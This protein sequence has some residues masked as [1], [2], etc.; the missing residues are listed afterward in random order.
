MPLSILPI[1]VPVNY[2]SY[3][4]ALDISGLRGEKTI[5]LNGSFDGLILVYG[6]HNGVNFA[7][8]FSFMGARPQSIKQIFNSS[9]QFIVLRCLARDMVAVNASISGEY[10]AVANSFASLPVVPAGAY[11]PQAIVDLFTLAP[12]DGL[13]EGTNLI[14][15]G[16]FVG[17]I[18]IEGSLDGLRFSPVASFK[19]LSRP[20]LGSG[21]QTTI[22]EHSPF[23]YTQQVR[24]LRVNVL[25]GTFVNGPLTITIGGENE[26]VADSATFLAEPVTNAAGSALLA[27]EVVRITGNEAVGRAQS[28]LV[29]NVNGLVGAMLHDTPLG[30]IDEVVNAGKGFVLL[31]AG[32]TP[33]PGDPLWVSE[34]TA[35]RATNVTPVIKAYMGVVK[36][37]SIYAATGGVIADINPGFTIAANVPATLAQ[38][39][40]VGVAP[41]DQTLILTDL[42]GGALVINATTPPPLF[43]GVTTFE[44]NVIGGSTNFYRIGGFDVSSAFTRAAALGMAWDEVAFLSST[45]TISG[46]T[47]PAITSLSMVTFEAG[48]ITAANPQTIGT[49]ATVTIEG[50]PTASNA[51]GASPTL[52]MPLALDVQTGDAHVSSG[53]LWTVKGITGTGVF[54]STYP[55]ALTTVLHQYDTQTTL[56]PVFLG[57]GNGVGGTNLS[58]SKSRSATGNAQAAVLNND[59]LATLSF[60]GDDGVDI[61]SGLAAQ[62]AV[63]VNGAPGIASVP[64]M[65]TFATNPVG[66]FAPV[67]RMRITSAGEVMVATTAATALANSKLVVKADATVA[68]PIAGTLWHGFELQPATM[69]LAAGGTVPDA[70]SLAYLAPPTITSPVAYVLPMGATLTIAGPPA[71]GGAL[72][73][74]NPLSLAVLDGTVATYFGIGGGDLIAS[75]FGGGAISLINQVDS[76]TY[77]NTVLAGFGNNDSGAELY[78]IKSRS[79]D[80]NASAIAQ[81]NDEVGSLYFEMDD[82]AGTASD[83]AIIEVR[84]DG[85][86][87]VGDTPGRIVFKTTPQGTFTP[88]ERMRIT[89][90]GN[91]LLGLTTDV[92]SSRLRVQADKTITAAGGALWNGIEFVA[93]T[94]TIGG[95]T[96]PITTMC[97]FSVAG[98]TITAA[99]AVVTTDF[100]TSRF[101]AA[102]FIGAG[103]ASATRSYSLFSEGNS[104]FGGGLTFKATDINAAGPYNVLETDFY[105]EVRYTATGAISINL[106]SIATAGSGRTIAV[107]DT[108]YNSGANNITMIPNGADK[109]NNAAGN[110]LI[111]I[112]GSCYWFKANTTTGNWEI[113]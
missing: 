28:N 87:A 21:S 40:S 96:T 37:A 71:E 97:F 47:I 64:G 61:G 66:G 51:G 78:L 84:V 59:Y 14:L 67:E 49:A 19:N 58:F 112:S 109:I 95:A 111:A 77:Y 52:S 2:G 31:E 103:P 104:K 6:S 100:Y 107:I 63:M 110:F 22:P 91:I 99:N 73:I 34:T 75:F 13:F 23:P 46:A 83:V 36:D 48:V 5:L 29:G 68:A 10:S 65:F 90:A 102:S 17:S 108:G 7:P 106:P 50:P 3:G 30:D 85:V 113:V 38:A 44:I 26:S 43:T 80:G 76:A 15:T 8:V 42:N 4:P 55:I 94:L 33:L 81:N 54:T 35:G 89:N 62:I 60:I 57:L 93:S 39:Y 11:G 56:G 98:P 105:L 88:V 27:G 53:A 18:S 25:N 12:P 20:T 74:T 16:D 82:G 79:T 45:L 32:L 24:Y 101:G 72:T 86:P 69:T 1:V 70:L 92:D 41:A 9:Y